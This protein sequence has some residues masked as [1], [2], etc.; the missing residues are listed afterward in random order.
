M[1]GIGAKLSLH[2]VQNWRQFDDQSNDFVGSLRKKTT[3]IDNPRTHYLNPVSHLHGQIISHTLGL[4]FSRPRVPSVKNP[5][6]CDS[7]GGG[8]ERNRQTKGWGSENT[9]IG[10]TL[11]EEGNTSFF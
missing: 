8:K 2:R 1:F 11:S 9:F 4:A 3:D 5:P 10:F 6:D 7:N